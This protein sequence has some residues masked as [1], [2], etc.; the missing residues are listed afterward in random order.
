[1]TIFGVCPPLL[2]L[3]LWAAYLS[4]AAV[5]GDFLG[6]QWDILLLETGFLT[7]FVVQP[8][9]LY[10][11]ASAADPPVVVLW[12]I[13]WLLF[14][15]MF[16]SG[17]VKLLSGDPTW[18]HLTA[19]QFHYETQPLPTW[20]GWYMHLLP[21]S[22][23]EISALFVFV[24]ELAAPF[25]IFTPRR[26]RMIGMWIL[27]SLQVL[28]LLTGNYC[29]F[30]LLTILLCLSLIEDSSWPTAIRRKIPSLGREETGLHWPRPLLYP[31][32]A[33]IFLLS[34]LQLG[35]TAGIRNWPTSALIVLRAAE[36]FESVNRY[37][38]FAV[39]TTSRPEIIIQGSNDGKEWR[40]YE[41]KYKP[42]DLKRA[43]GFVAPYQPRL[44]W[45]MWFAA[46]G[47]YQENEWFIPFCERLLNGSPE[48]L[49]LMQTNPFSSHPPAFIRA[50][51]YDYHFT[52]Y[53][54]KKT[55]GMWWRRDHEREY[56]PAISLQQ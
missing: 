36:P 33:I 11:P 19:L 6:F 34:L 44:D 39:M 27:V 55:R 50:V 41:F 20:I 7:I 3:L 12:M 2:F 40:D 31:I 42:G 32:M 53:T 24:A 46:L 4:L 15:L 18:H 56:M 23:H 51:I 38:L 25:L 14:R 8:T 10:K 49:G 30:N 37:G 1:M 45:Q 22:V 35:V 47:T 48:V 9:K 16:S 17:M 13:R 52:D 54:T 29:F 5:C 28:I 26:Y 43:P 21:N